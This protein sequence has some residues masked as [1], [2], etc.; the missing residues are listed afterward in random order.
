VT[1][2]KFTADK[3]A[4]IEKT[5]IAKN[6]SISLDAVDRAIKKIDLGRAETKLKL[7]DYMKGAK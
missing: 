1:K 7:D 2:V 6:D 5:L 4:L 3:I